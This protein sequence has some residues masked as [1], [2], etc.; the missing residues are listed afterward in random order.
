MAKKTVLAVAVL[1][2]ISSLAFQ[3]AKPSAKGKEVYN[4]QCVTCHGPM[5]AGIKD[6][7]PPL[8]KSDF[9]NADKTRAIHIVL[10]GQTGK[11]KVNGAEYDSEMMSFE[12]TDQ[13]IS[14]V[15][16]YVRNSWGNKGTP[17]TPEEVATVRKQTAK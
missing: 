16:N 4:S 13:Q 6:V 15:L 9:L 12:L 11:I 17:V 3:A 10:H 8:A 5:G 14:D 7:Y 1:L 2:A